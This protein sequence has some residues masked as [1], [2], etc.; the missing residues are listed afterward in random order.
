MDLDRI[1]SLKPNEVI[2]GKNLD[3]AAV[4][5]H[6]VR[7]CEKSNEIVKHQRKLDKLN[8]VLKQLN[9]IQSIRMNTSNA[10]DL[11]EIH[12]C[13]R[14]GQSSLVVGVEIELVNKSM[15]I[16]NDSHYL[17]VCVR[18]EKLGTNQSSYWKYKFEK[19]RANSHK[20]FMDSSG[21]LN[22]QYY[23]GLVKLYLVYDV[24]S[25]LAQS[26]EMDVEN[27]SEF[28]M[29]LYECEFKI[30]EFFGA[31]NLNEN[32]IEPNMSQIL[33]N[34]FGEYYK[35]YNFSERL[36]EMWKSLS[37]QGLIGTENLFSGKT[38]NLLDGLYLRFLEFKQKIKSCFS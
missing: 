8:F 37:I 23:P 17:L 21:E 36:D 12:K 2:I 19:L 15:R 1:S 35:K 13:I 24:R 28:S 11:F 6:M 38:I 9:Q 18:F 20:V 5:Q 34:V 32:R 3:K 33:W 29:C 22:R 7:L 14:R 26:D 4:K 27:L 31:D 30:D 25:F 10:A 16:E